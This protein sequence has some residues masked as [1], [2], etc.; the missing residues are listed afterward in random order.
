MSFIPGQ[1]VTAV[2]V[3]LRSVWESFSMESFTSISAFSFVCGAL[4][5]LQQQ[6]FIL[7][8]LTGKPVNLKMFFILNNNPIG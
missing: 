1:P 7:Y 3:S 6:W 2:V 5:Y 8:R 4:V